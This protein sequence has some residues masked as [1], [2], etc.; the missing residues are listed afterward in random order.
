MSAGSRKLV[1]L[2]ALVAGGIA[3]GVIAERAAVSRR[4]RGGPA[5]DEPFGLLRGETVDVFAQDGVRL[6]VEVDEPDPA[7]APLS[8]D[9][10]GADRAGAAL[11]IIFV[12]GYGLSQ[13][14]FHYQR[15]ELRG[16]YRLIFA[17]QRAHGR[18]G[19]GAPDRSTLDQLG[20]DLRT[21]IDAVV[22]SGPVVLVGH[23]MGGMTILTLAGQDPEFFRRRVVGVGLLATTSGQLFDEPFG[24]P[25]LMSRALNRV[26][27]VALTAAMRRQPLIE[28]ARHQAT[29]LVFALTNRY[30]FGSPV[31]PTL[32]KFVAD[33]VA[34]TPV[35]VIAEYLGT[36]QVFNRSEAVAVLEGIETLIMV[37]DRDRV[38]PLPHSIEIV[39]RAPHAEFVL[40]P[41][42]GHMLMLERF[43]EVNRHLHYLLDRVGAGLAARAGDES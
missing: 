40:L 12:H 42:T 20:R 5:L 33:M 39:R 24:L 37:G 16:K 34:D 8:G 11:P 19:R 3:A 4:L 14:C 38:T 15:A 26:A 32:T 1:G 22:P 17:D 13:D 29:D 36:L 6:H 10:A 41:D 35:D 31:S 27:P 28:A 18:S 25:V 23:S 30:S 21:I 2:A 9:P 43:A 7:R